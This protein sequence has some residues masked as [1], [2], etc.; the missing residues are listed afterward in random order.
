MAAR[1]ESAATPRLNTDPLSP[2]CVTRSPRF[3]EHSNQPSSM[4]R[5]VS[6]R[7]KSPARCHQ[8]A[9]VAIRDRKRVPSGDTSPTA[10]RACAPACISLEKK[11]NGASSRRPNN[12]SVFQAPVLTSLL[13]RPP[14]SDVIHYLST[15]TIPR[16]G[17]RTHDG[18]SFARAQRLS[19]IAERVST[20]WHEGLP[21]SSTLREAGRISRR[22]VT[23]CGCAHAR[24][25]GSFERTNSSA[26]RCPQCADW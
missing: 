14:A 9:Q 4:R 7:A 1:D 10:W 2:T 23:Y 22:S 13:E 16:P 11:S 25:L 12:R 8:L 17:I 21:S 26:S 6:T 15:T 24:P 5:A 20:T 18:S 3:P 19:E